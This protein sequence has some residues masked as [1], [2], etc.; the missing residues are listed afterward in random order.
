MIKTSFSPKTPKELP[1]RLDKEKV[2]ELVKFDVNAEHF[3]VEI[4]VTSQKSSDLLLR[5]PLLP[6]EELSHRL[7]SHF[8]EASLLQQRKHTPR[9]DSHHQVSRPECLH[10]MRL[11]LQGE[12][13]RGRSP[14]QDQE[15]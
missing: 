9:Q 4:L 12:E 10:R 13:R 1:E 11:D 2:G 15:Y 3:L 8:E 14:S 6:E 7:W 5:K